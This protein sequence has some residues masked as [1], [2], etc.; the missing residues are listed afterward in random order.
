MWTDKFYSPDGDGGGSA[1]LGDEGD[2]GVVTEPTPSEPVSQEGGTVTPTE[3]QTPPVGDSGTQ[4]SYFR[5]LYNEKGEIN[6]DAWD[7]L[8]EHLKEGS[9]FFSRYKTVDDLLGTMLHQRQALS[10][11][12]M[13]RPEENAPDEVKEAFNAKMRELSGAPEN[14]SDYDFNRPEGLPEAIPWDEE[15][16]GKFAEVAHKHGMSPELA[17]DLKEVY[18]ELLQGDFTGTETNFKTN[19]EQALKALGADAGKLGKDAKDTMLTLGFSEEDANSLANLAV[20]SGMGETF[21][22]NMANMHNLMDKAKFVNAGSQGAV[23]DGG[24]Q[25]ANERAQELFAK[26]MEA[27]DAGNKAEGDR[28]D[29]EAT[30]QIKI[31]QQRGEI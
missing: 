10:K 25:T 8:P 31:A 14:A 29:R 23:M 1:I 21:V 9:K 13:A 4:E 16:Q 11:D 7:R 24:G 18:A 5:G 19:E 17:Q 2:G 6:A 20:A 22:R 26:S 28:L 15:T 3:P 30:H 12:G 27:Y